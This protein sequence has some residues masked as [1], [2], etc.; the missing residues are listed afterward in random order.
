ML[1]HEPTE[2]YTTKGDLGLGKVYINETQFFDNVPQVRME[3]LYR[4][5]SASSEVA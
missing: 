4:W 1:L 3:F 5:L 2:E